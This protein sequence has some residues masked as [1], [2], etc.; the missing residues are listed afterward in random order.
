VNAYERIK[1]AQAKEER[2]IVNAIL[3]DGGFKALGAGVR[4]AT[5]N[6]L[7]RLERRSWIARDRQDGRWRL[8]AQGRSAIAQD[9]PRQAQVDAEGA[10]ALRQK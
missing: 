2:R 4:H 1:S 9:H 8:T 3:E 10:A 5:W 7:E 6:A